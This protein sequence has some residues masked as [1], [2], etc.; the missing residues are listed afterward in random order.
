MKPFKLHYREN[1]KKKTIHVYARTLAS[2][3]KTASN[4]YYIDRAKLYV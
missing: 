2:A 1:G 3:M 4:L